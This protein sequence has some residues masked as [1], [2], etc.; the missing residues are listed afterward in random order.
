MA[1]EWDNTNRK[2]HRAIDTTIQNL[3]IE[4]FACLFLYDK[5]AM[6]IKKCHLKF[7]QQQVVMTYHTKNTVNNDKTHVIDVRS[8]SR[9]NDQPKKDPTKWTYSPMFCSIPQLGN[10]QL[11]QRVTT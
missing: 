9:I 8:P 1:L 11:W 10:Q 3:K 6:L 5:M 4:M 7:L 2:K